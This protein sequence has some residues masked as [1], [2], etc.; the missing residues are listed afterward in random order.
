[1]KR[2]LGL[3]KKE[4]EG[5]I[6]DRFF[7]LLDQLP[8]EVI[9]TMNEVMSMDAPTIHDVRI[10][11][12]RHGAP[13]HVVLAL[14]GYLPS[15]YG[16]HYVSLGYGPLEERVQVRDQAHYVAYRIFS[17]GCLANRG[18]NPKVEVLPEA[19]PQ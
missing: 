12:A 1:M 11:A 15:T 13:E 5:M 14:H 18:Q 16:D 8:G 17:E 9:D 19:R 10:A 6:T 4:W 3:T 7:E 2:R